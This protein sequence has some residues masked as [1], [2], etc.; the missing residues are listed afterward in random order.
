MHG[1]YMEIVLPFGKNQQLLGQVP[2]T[3]W[4]KAAENADFS[5]TYVYE[6]KVNLRD[7]ERG[8]ILA[9]LEHFKKC[10]VRTA[11]ALGVT[12]KTLYNKLHSFGLSDEYKAI[13]TK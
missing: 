12:V 2:V 11:Q 3:Y 5:V 10:K 8:Y 9:A 4:D 13:R 1:G 6:P 7:L